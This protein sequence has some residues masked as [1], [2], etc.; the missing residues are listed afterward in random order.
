MIAHRAL[1]FPPIKRLHLLH[2]LTLF[3]LA[4]IAGHRGTPLAE[5]I[6]HFLPNSPISTHPFSVGLTANYT[7]LS[8]C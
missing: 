7:T 6:A 3:P 4:T 1:A 2:T 8:D 5:H